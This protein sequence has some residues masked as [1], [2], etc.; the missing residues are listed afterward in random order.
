M[1]QADKV[2]KLLPCPFDG[3][4]D[5]IMWGGYGTQAE[6]YCKECGVEKSV[7]VSDLFEYYERPEFDMHT[8][9]YSEDVVKKVKIYLA[10]VWNTR[11]PTAREQELEREVERLQQPGGDNTHADN[12][13]WVFV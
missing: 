4:N 9:S 13:R 7:Q 6:V 2:I 5:I 12:K 8:A 3:S 11:A 10:E 1:T